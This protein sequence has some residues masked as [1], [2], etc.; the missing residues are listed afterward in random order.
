[1][2]EVLPNWHPVFVHFSVALFSISTLVFFIS[3]FAPGYSVRYQ[4]RLIAR[5][6]LW[7]GMFLTFF[8]VAAGMYAFYTVN[9]D[10]PSHAVMIIH[11]Y[12]AIATMTIFIVLSIWSVVCARTQREEGKSYLFLSFIGFLLLSITAWYGGELVYRHGLGVQSIPAPSAGGHNHGDHDHGDSA[13][14]QHEDL[15]EGGRI[16]DSEQTNSSSHSH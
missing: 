15:M 8:T 10:T 6:N 14:T 4:T 5:W 1:M 2:I 9:H 12:F 7:I 11:R 13:P 3:V 16:D